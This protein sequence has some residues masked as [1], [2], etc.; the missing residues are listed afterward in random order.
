M[1]REIKI[2][3]YVCVEC[4]EED[5][6]EGTLRGSD[7]VWPGREIYSQRET[8]QEELERKEN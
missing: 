7:F 8:E 6:Q 1:G 3:F 5:Q 2:R 4:G